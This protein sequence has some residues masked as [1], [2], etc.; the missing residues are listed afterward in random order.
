MNEN[1]IPR[2]IRLDLSEPA[3]LAIRKAV[4]EVEKVGASIGLTK[5]VSLLHEARELVADYIDKV[6]K[7][8]T[9][10]PDW[11]DPETLKNTADQL[12]SLQASMDILVDDNERLSKR[13]MRWVKASERLPESKK[14]YC[15]KL[16]GKP[17]LVSDWNLRKGWISVNNNLERI[18]DVEWLDESESI[19]PK[20]EEWIGEYAD[21]LQQAANLLDKVYVKIRP[22]CQS[23]SDTSLLFYEA[24]DKVQSIKS[25]LNSKRFHPKEKK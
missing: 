7:V 1:K 5:A 23:Q 18:E 12:S 14:L 17:A 10:V 4:D 13:G 15:G 24:F 25:K 9:F 8:N 20:G 22:F 11:N 19:I 21:I 2:R 16:K 6:E 3:E